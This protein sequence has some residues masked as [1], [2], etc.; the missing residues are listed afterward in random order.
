MV[1]SST[2]LALLKQFE[3]CNLTAYQDQRGVWTIGYGH[4]GPEVKEGLVST[5]AQADAQLAADVATRAQPFVNALIHAG[6]SM[7][8]NEFDAL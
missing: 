6:G 8:Q 5:Q 4:T 2:G 3:G 1:L 7:P